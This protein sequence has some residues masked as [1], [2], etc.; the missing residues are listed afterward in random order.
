MHHKNDLFTSI[1]DRSRPNADVEEGHIS[2]ACCILANLS[3]DLGRS[4]KYDPKTRTVI[5][6]PE[7]TQKLSRPY[8]GDWQHPDPKMV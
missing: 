3:L 4:L 5:G 1:K 2:S 8:R 7:A 6:D